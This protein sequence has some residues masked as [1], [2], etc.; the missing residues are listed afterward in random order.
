ML[1]NASKRTA[2][3]H[4]GLI[5][6]IFSMLAKSWVANINTYSIDLVI[7]INMLP[8]KRTAWIKF[9]KKLFDG[10][11]RRPV[12]HIFVATSSVM[13]KGG[14]RSQD[15]VPVY[16]SPIPRQQKKGEPA[17]STFA[18]QK[19]MELVSP[20]TRAFCENEKYKQNSFVSACRNCSLN[21]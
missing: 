3:P 16:W 11:R 20:D 12:R 18:H 15:F 19:I 14:T 10:R 8:N 13:G 9:K 2:F 1:F 7:T 5:L 21:F 4:Q 6:G 17:G